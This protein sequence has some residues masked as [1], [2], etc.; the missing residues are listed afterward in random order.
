MGREDR[1]NEL[2]SFR[3]PSLL[4]SLLFQSVGAHQIDASEMRCIQMNTHS[5]LPKL[6]RGGKYRNETWN[7]DDI[8]STRRQPRCC[9][10]S[11]ISGILD[12][13]LGIVLLPCQSST[14]PF[15]HIGFALRDSLSPIARRSAREETMRLL[16]PVVAVASLVPTALSWGAAGQPRYLIHK[17]SC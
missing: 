17:C 14:F 12:S 15:H 6:I 5:S 3:C 1:L 4:L 2:E 9:Y 7:D 13:L 10:H 16:L 8:S 11:T